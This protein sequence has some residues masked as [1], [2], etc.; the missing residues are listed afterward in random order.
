MYTKYK[1]KKYLN[2]D[3]LMRVTCSAMCIPETSTSF[4]Y[5][6]RTREKKIS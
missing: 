1:T 6:Y 2:Y 4:L 3:D 5:T